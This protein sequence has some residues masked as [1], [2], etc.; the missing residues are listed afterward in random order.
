MVDNIPLEPLMKEIPKDSLNFRREKEK[1]FM[2]GTSSTLSG[3]VITRTGVIDTKF[4]KEFVIRK[5]IVTCSSLD[6]SN[7]LKSTTVWLTISG[8]TI[9][10]VEDGA[11]IVLD[12]GEDEFIVGKDTSYIFRKVGGYSTTNSATFTALGFGYS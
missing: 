2:W 10:M 5:I 6:Q 7:V 11:S 1:G 9:A 12:F 4:Y 3:S 8:V